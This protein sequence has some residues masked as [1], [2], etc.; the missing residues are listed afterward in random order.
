MASPDLESALN[1]VNGQVI[2]LSLRWKIFCQLFD[3]GPENIEL[4]NKSGRNVFSLFQRL[5]LDDVMIS[6]SRLT[7]PE[8][9]LGSENASIRN[10]V[11]KAKAC[12]SAATIA[13][14]EALVSELDNHVL[15][16]R[17]HRNKALAHAD[18]GHALNVSA[19]PCVT[20]D[21]LEKAM[22]TLQEIVSRVASEAF[23]WTT[24]Y[25]RTIQYGCGGDSL[26]KVLKRGH[27]DQAK[28]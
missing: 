18:L 22:K 27:S 17:K 1:A 25:D 26:L 24:H 20:Y 5:V 10:V 13:E 16:V 6:L 7:D 9:S 23:R 3:S 15:N 28:G 12:L 11:A 21:E 4:L 19:L 14:V 8:K 2:Q